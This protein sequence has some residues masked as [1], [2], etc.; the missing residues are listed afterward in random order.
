MKRTT[1]KRTKEV[2]NLLGH[3]H[4]PIVFDM[5]LLTK[6]LEVTWSCPDELQGVIPCEGGM[7]LLMSVFAGIGCIYGDAGLRQLLHESGVFAMG[8]VQQMLT[9]KDFD[10]A[11]RG[12][13][14]VDDALTTVFLKEFKSWCS[15]KNKTNKSRL[16]LEMSRHFLTT[17]A[18]S[19]ICTH[20]ASG[21][22]C[23]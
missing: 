9:G 13:R 2:I 23:I 21:K 6:A 1:L 12:L 19:T 17:C 8:T 16:S 3:T 20:C 22:I 18:S 4:A 15:T 11:L 7:H 5:G 10:R 14:L